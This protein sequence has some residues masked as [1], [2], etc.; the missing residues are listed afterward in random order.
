MIL[1]RA[2]ANEK[3]G[4]GHVMRCL[5]IAR[6]FIDNGNKVIFVTADHRGD[7]LIAEQGFE[8]ICL[9]SDWTD[10]ESEKL[11]KVVKEY[12]PELLLLDSY[13]VTDDYL[14]CLKR[15]VRTAYIDDLNNHYWDVDYLINYNIFAS[16]FDYSKYDGTRTKLLLNP[17]YAPLRDEFKRC[18]KHEIKDVTDVIVSAGGADPEHI[19]EKILSGICPEMESVIFHFIVGALNPSLEY[20]KNIAEGKENVILHINE[21]HMSDLMKKCDIAISASGT[22]LYELCATG[23]PTITYTLAD[24]QLVAA[25]QFDKQGI[26]IS[27]GDCRSDDEFIGRLESLLKNLVNNE[28]LRRKL[29]EKMQTLVDGNGAARIADMLLED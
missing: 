18:T 5:S 26:M 8:T 4:T 25:E 2:D 28:A 19:T 3:I 9:D 20:I 23:I 10:M 15:I 6:A 14:N 27:V 11:D 29:S 12:K 22:T 13:Y 16:I 21:K 17:Q 7:G 24:N 1:I